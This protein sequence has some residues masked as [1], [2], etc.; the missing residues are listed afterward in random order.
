MVDPPTV[1]IATT[2]KGKLREARAILAGLPV[3]ITTLADHPSLPVPVEDAETFE[4]NARL[5]ALHYARLSGCLTLADEELESDMRSGEKMARIKENVERGDRY[6]LE[7]TPMVVFDG[8]YK[9][10]SL[11]IGN[12]KKIIDDLLAL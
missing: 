12:L 2:N 4:G 1:L 3:R 6:A 10:N 11:A 5:K 7:G 9:A 8:Q